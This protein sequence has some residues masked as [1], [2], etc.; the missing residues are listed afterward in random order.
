[1]ALVNFIKIYI[2]KKRA[3][4]YNEYMNNY[5][6]ERRKNMDFELEQTNIDF[7]KIENIK[8]KMT[9]EDTIFDMAE[10]FKVFGDSTR[11]KI[12][13]ALL[14]DELCVG[15]IVMIT[16]STQS[17]ISHQL[18]VLKQSKLVKYRKEGKTVYY[19]LDDNHIYQIYNLVKEH[20]EE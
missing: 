1:M 8:S 20:I 14:E 16:N 18:R 11:M 4:S 10:F 3:Q 15:E 5:S 12:I 6:Y 9:N 13:S 17:A 19:S 7:N 2:D